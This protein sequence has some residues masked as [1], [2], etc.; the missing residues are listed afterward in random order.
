V[1]TEKTFQNPGLLISLSTDKPL[2]HSNEVMKI[3]VGVVSMNQMNVQLKVYGI[4]ASRNR[5]DNVQ[6]VNIIAGENKFSVDYTAPS[7]NTCSGI[8]AGNYS[9][10]AELVSGNK[11]LAKVVK[12]VEIQQ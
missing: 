3:D 10:T 6:D 11:S 4:Y 1:T 2:Y 12:N 9:I 7:C 5:L 8:K